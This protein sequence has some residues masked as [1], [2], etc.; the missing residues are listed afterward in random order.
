MPDWS[1]ILQV[2][3]L[4]LL[5]VGG[6]L[7]ALFKT[8]AE[9]AVKASAEEGAKA[10]IREL[11]WTKVLARELQKSRGQERQE[12]RFRAY[13]GLWKELRPLAIYDPTDIDNEIAADLLTKLTAW[14]FSE[15]GGLL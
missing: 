6:Y 7:L 2:A 13:G 11:E 10:A 15:C 3:T 9:A 4:I 1:V 12:L 14:Y 8:G 5:G